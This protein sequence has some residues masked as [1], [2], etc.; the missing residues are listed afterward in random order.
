MSKWEV[1]KV[2]DNRWTIARRID[3]ST[4]LGMLCGRRT[5]A[6]L[7]EDEAIVVAKML[8][9]IDACDGDCTVFVVE[10]G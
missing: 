2:G 6:E 9:E 10:K 7:Y 3:D 1:V 8:N 4:R 5:G